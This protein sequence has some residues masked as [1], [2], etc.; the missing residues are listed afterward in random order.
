MFVFYEVD[1]QNYP[2]VTSILGIRKTEGLKKWRESIGEDVANFE[3]RRAANRGKATHNLVENYIKGLEDKGHLIL[4]H[5]A[6]IR[7]DLQEEVSEMLRKKIYGHFN[8]TAFRVHHSKKNP[9]I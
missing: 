7:D 2:S 3:M 4:E 6:E 5:A 8:I 9:K 1:G